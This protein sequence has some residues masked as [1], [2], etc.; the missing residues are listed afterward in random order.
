MKSILLCASL[1]FSS[2]VALG[3]NLEIGSELKP[4]T[5]E[6]L[7]SNEF[8][9]DAN[10]VPC[11]LV[12]V[13]LPVENVKFEGNIIDSEYKTNEYWVFLSAGTK[14][15]RIKCPGALPLD[16]DATEIEPNG[17]KSKC[18]YSISLHFNS[19]RQQNSNVTETP[20]KEYF[21]E[22]LVTN[23]FGFMPINSLLKDSKTTYETA[24]AAGLNPTLKD[25]GDV[26]VYM[27]SEPE[28]CKG[29]N[30]IKML[31][32]L[33]GTDIIP[34][35]VSMGYE[36]SK[37]SDGRITYQFNWPHANNTERRKIGREKSVEFSKY[38]LNQLKNAG[39][40]MTGDYKSAK[41]LTSLGEITLVCN[42]N[43]GSCWVGLY[44]DTYYKKK[45]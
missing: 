34:E 9:K 43:Y 35:D 8:R 30:A 4:Q 1:L 40:D 42:D 7:T 23:A 41:C 25:G 37:Y 45:D 12:K 21:V 14:R 17:L 27:T 2:I 33:E 44:V 11:A 16:I 19:K 15:L 29:F 36:P 39:Y 20:I 26:G 31:C 38:I 3:Q 24:K 13:Q 6:V 5:F 32:K 28:K 22:D 10:G 18:V